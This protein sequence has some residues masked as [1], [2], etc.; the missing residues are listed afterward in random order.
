MEKFFKAKQKLVFVLGSLKTG[1]AERNLAKTASYFAQ[2]DYEVHVLLF[3]NIIE[4]ALHPSI[5]VHCIG[6]S[7]YPNKLVKAFRLYA[8]VF[9]TVWNLR[10]QYA[11]GFARISSQTLALTFYP[12]IIA[13]FDSYPFDIRWYRTFFALT[14]FNFFNVKSVVCPSREI[15]DKIGPYFMDK[16]K[17]K[18]IGNP[19]DICAAST[20]TDIPELPTLNKYIIV[21]GRLSERKHVDTVIRAYSNSAIHHRFELVIA[22]DGPEAYTLRE[23]AATSSVSKKIHFTGHVKHPQKFIQCAS[24][25]VLASSKE[26]FPTVLVEALALGVPV[27]S[28]DCRSGPAEIVQQGINGWLYPLTEKNALVKK[29]EEIAADPHIIAEVAKNARVSVLAFSTEEVMGK[30]KEIFVT[31]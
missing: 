28:S 8:G 6:L 10:P 11:I 26:G 24:L 17:L 20:E 12:R 15:K 30:W 19:V 22:G 13:R 25:L 23:M 2:N 29:F 27:L 18:T 7:R 1:G 9:K 5:Q 3:E 4:F 16:S 21:V 14:I 31:T